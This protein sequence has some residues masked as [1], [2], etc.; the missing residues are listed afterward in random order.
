MATPSISALE[1]YTI[2]LASKSPRRKML[3]EGLGFPFEVRTHEVDED[4]PADLVGGE[5]PIFLA[6]KKAKAFEDERRDNEIIVTADT[7]VWV[8]GR[9]LN[10]PANR[11][12]AK[13]MLAEI[14]GVTHSVF[15]GVCL[16]V[17]ERQHSFVEET[18]VTFRS[19]SSEEIDYYLDHYAPYDKAGAYGIQ[20]FI[21]LIGIQRVEGDFYNVVGFPMQRFW[22]E[23]QSML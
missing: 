7:I 12:E 15:T 11:D 17:G 4:F 23:L 8:N 13:A 18:E 6:E 3:F 5:I 22:L 10:K 14:S 21:G 9:A 2:V 19:L 1:P 16:T 20:E